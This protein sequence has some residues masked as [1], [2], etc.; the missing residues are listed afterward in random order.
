MKKLLMS[1]IVFSL[2]FPTI[3]NAAL[4]Y[5]NKQC[6]KLG[7]D[8]LVTIKGLLYEIAQEQ[9]KET[10]KTFSPHVADTIV[11]MEKKHKEEKTYKLSEYKKDDRARLIT[12]AVDLIIDVLS[13]KTKFNPQKALLRWTETGIKV[14]A[15]YS[16]K[17][18]NKQIVSE[19]KLEL[20]ND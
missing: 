4:V 14:L 1:L 2:M 15:E 18:V 5:C 6:F 16:E 17:I 9:D 12:Q 20:A 13:E 19:Y 10:Q 7:S 3:S 11:W 8:Q